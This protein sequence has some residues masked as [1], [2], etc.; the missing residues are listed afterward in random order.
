MKE[1]IITHNRTKE[2]LVTASNVTEW[3][4]Y[5]VDGKWCLGITYFD[6][7]IEQDIRDAMTLCDASS[8]K[9]KDDLTVQ[10][11]EQ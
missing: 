9:W 10:W 5:K 2:L 7:D 8:D 1:L 4:I 6:E 11:T 3:K